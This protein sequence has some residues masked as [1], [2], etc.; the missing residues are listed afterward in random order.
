MRFF[1][2]DGFLYRALTWVA[3]FAL[4]SLL[5]LV[6]CFP[7]V[8]AP[9]GVAALFGVSRRMLREGDVPVFRAFFQLFAENFKQS[10]I[11]GWILGIVTFL[12]VTDFRI[13]SAVHTSLY[14]VLTAALSVTF[15]I[16]ALVW[17]HLFSLMVHMRM[18][19]RQLFVSALKISF[20]KAHLSIANLAFLV[21]AFLIAARF[22]FFLFFFY[23]GVC[24]FVTY[25]FVD[26]KFQALQRLQDDRS[27]KE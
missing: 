16:L 4:M 26:R 19:I 13:V 6:A 14:P 25:W 7:I 8:T 10:M 15:L 3:N 5:F 22:P 23:P 20:Y 11:C 27:S 18:T 21:F 1:S 12:G 9:A 24:A 2:M 17:L